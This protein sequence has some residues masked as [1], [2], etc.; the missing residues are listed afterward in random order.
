MALYDQLGF[1]SPL[2]LAK[3][4]YDLRERLGEALDAPVP[5]QLEPLIDRIAEGE[6]PR[7]VL[8]LKSGE[9]QRI[10]DDAP[11]T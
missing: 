11:L 5:E 10:E 6:Q 3:L 1:E 7:D 4:G 8:T 2:V 9:Y